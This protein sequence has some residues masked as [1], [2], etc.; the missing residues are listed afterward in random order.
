MTPYEAVYG[1]R[2]PIVTTY[3]LGTSKFQYIDKMLQVRTTTL[4][5]LKDN[6]HM[7]QNHMKQQPY[8]HHLERVFQADDQVFIR[9]HPYKKTSLKSQGHHKLE[10]KFYGPY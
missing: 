5:A 7:A 6:L 8:Q 2:P 1:Q 10:P 4:E 3:L 9:L